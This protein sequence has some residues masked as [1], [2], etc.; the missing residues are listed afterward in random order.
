[1]A[2]WYW[3]AHQTLSVYLQSYGIWELSR[4]QGKYFLHWS[5]D[6]INGKDISFKSNGN[7]SRLTID[8]FLVSFVYGHRSTT[9]RY[10]WPP[11]LT[12][13][14]LDLSYRS[15]FFQTLPD[16]PKHFLIDNFLRLFHVFVKKGNWKRIVDYLGTARNNFFC[17]SRN[18]WGNSRGDYWSGSFWRQHHWSVFINMNIGLVWRTQTSYSIDRQNW[19]WKMSVKGNYSGDDFSKS[20]PIHGEDTVFANMKGRVPEYLN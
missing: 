9:L 11:S 2:H 10:W 20:D 6:G 7:Q 4:L 5:F 1:M 14:M 15:D 16:P 19:L 8:P 12:T 18:R 17:W 3:A 13:L